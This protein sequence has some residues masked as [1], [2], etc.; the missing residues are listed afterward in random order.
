MDQV[1]YLSLSN[2][3]RIISYSSQAKS[4]RAKNVLSSE[5][6]VWLF[7]IRPYGLVILDYLSILW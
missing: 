2:N 3:A 1:N 5:Q 4:C 6:N 7:N